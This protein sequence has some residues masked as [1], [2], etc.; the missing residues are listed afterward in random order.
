M[1]RDNQIPSRKEVSPSD[2]WDLSKLFL[3]DEAWEKALSKYQG[4]IPKLESFKGSLGSSPEHLYD[5]MEFLTEAGKL[6]ERIGY[7]AMLKYS[8]DAGKTENQSRYGRMMQADSAMSAAASFIN[9]E[10]QAIDDETMAEFL[11]D[12]ALEEYRITLKKILRFKPHVLTSS[13][14]RLLALQQE[15]AQTAQ[16]S[17]AALTDVDLEFGSIT[18]DGTKQPISQSTYAK[19]MQNRD[20][21]VRKKAFK[22]FYRAF[23]A[24]KNTLSSLYAGSIQQDVFEAR[25]RG[26]SSSRAAALF[27]DNVPEKVYDNLISSVHDSLPAVHRYYQ[28]RRDLLK[29][30]VLRHYDVYVPLVGNIDTRYSYQEA[31]E[32]VTEALTPLGSEY[33]TT[34]HTGLLGGWV[35]RYENKGKRS[36]AF[37]AGSY[38]GD[39]YIL[40][41]YKEDVLRDVFTLAHEAGHSMHSWYSVKNNPFQH[42]NYSIFEAEVASTFNEQLLADYMLKQND[43]PKMRSFIIGKQIDDIIATIYRQTMFAEFEKIT[44]QAYEEGQALTLDLFRN[45]YRK[46]L[47]TYFGSVMKLESDSD[48]EGLRIP[49]FYRSFYVYKYAT[50]LSAATALSQRVLKGGKQ[51]LEDYMSFLRSGGSR[52]PIDSLRL[53][54]VDMASPEPIKK[55]LEKFDQLVAQF[56]D[57][58]GY[59][60]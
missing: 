3:N 20:R 26:Y 11:D 25:V 19:L 28:M 50:G 4:L 57:S 30:D 9:P 1:S 38:V 40:L 44:H 60:F 7:Y 37:S 15:P 16:K 51:E 31:V 46:L 27:P 32:L 48:L 23:D 36:G 35:D 5:C 58:V 59:T 14:E 55:A 52:Y 8:E 2:T 41:N 21:D 56:A 54:G 22:K 12:P 17:F 13:E 18:V 39:P 42:Y 45:E 47:K 34:M 43:D 24:H 33:T 53:A 29:T 49:H 10:I 6:G